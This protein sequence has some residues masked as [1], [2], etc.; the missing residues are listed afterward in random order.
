MKIEE[1]IL[2]ELKDIKNILVGKKTVCKAEF[3][4]EL[5]NGRFID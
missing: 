5:K 1:L 4:P 3:K 2:A